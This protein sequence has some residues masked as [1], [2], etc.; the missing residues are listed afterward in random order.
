MEKKLPKMGRRGIPGIMVGYRT[1][2][3]GK[4]T[5]DYKIIPICDFDFTKTTTRH[6]RCFSIKEVI[7]PD[8]SK[9]KFPLRKVLDRETRE[10]KSLKKDAIMHDVAT[11]GHDD[12]RK[13]EKAQN[14]VIRQ[15]PLVNGGVIDVKLGNSEAVGRERIC[16]L[17][18]LMC[19]SIM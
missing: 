4:W 11:T 16:T 10:I 2:P 18:Q 17:L 7:L 19:S 8:N 15:K 13:S 6:V 9:W 5:G 14:F 3:G 1:H 12:H